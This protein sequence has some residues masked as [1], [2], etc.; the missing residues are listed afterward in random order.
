MITNL[1]IKVS[2]K[3]LLLTLSF[4]LCLSMFF[5]GG[6]GLISEYELGTYSSHIL[7]NGYKELYLIIGLMMCAMGIGCAIQGLIKNVTIAKFFYLETVL[8]LIGGYSPTILYWVHV[9]LPDVYFTYTLNGLALTIGILIG[10]EIPF[11]VRLISGLIGKEVTVGKSNWSALAIV[12]GFVMGADY[13]GS[14]VGSRVWVDY[15]LVNHPLTE[16]SFVASGTNYLVAVISLIVW[17]KYLSSTQIKYVIVIFIIS[18]TTLGYG[19]SNNIEWEGLL[20]Q[21]L[22]RDQIVHD[23]ET[24]NGGKDRSPY[25]KIILTKSKIPGLNGKPFH[26]LFLNGNKQWQEDDEYKY[27]ESLVHPPAAILAKQGKLKNVLILGGGDGFAAREVLKY[28][29]LENLVLVDLDPAVVKLHSTNSTLVAL[30]NS[31]FKDARIKVLPPSGLTD[32]KIRDVFMVSQKA[33]KGEQTKL[34]SIGKTR[35]FHMDADRFIGALPDVKWDIVIID[36]P[37]PKTHAVAKLY[38]LEFYTKLFKILNSGA[39]VSIQATSPYHLKEAFLNIKRTMEAAG[40]KTIPY[41]TNIVSFGEW[42]FLLA[43]IDNRSPDF[44]K[45]QFSMLNEFS[46]PTK[47]LTPEVFLAQTVFGKEGLKSKLPK[48]KQRI[49]TLN[50][51]TLLT[52]YMNDYKV[53]E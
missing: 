6:V 45:G 32:G 23:S 38:S 17:W 48:N 41:H 22:F 5:S 28:P 3:V 2:P 51:S 13:I 21:K 15:L 12:V 11:V 40:F 31:A 30:N 8:A 39:M 34:T 10:I 24:S 27:H 43:W 50:R 42:G 20:R 29:Q 19:Y 52:A 36:F 47:Y 1:E 14:W 4:F 44:V 7:G 18:V 9:N 33:P 16:I 53:M 46:V 26:T 37:D 25:Q 35:V 49:N